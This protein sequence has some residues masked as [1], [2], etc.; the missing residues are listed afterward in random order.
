MVSVHP[1]STDAV[2]DLNRS[3]VNAQTGKDTWY[4]P[5]MQCEIDAGKEFPIQFLRG[6]SLSLINATT[7]E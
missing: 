2:K 5:N 1:S 7:T 6:L 3:D 4:G